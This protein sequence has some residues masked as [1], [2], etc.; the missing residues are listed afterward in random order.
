[1]KKVSMAAAGLVLVVGLAACHNDKC[2]D[3]G[4]SGTCCTD[5]G[6]ST[7]KSSS[8]NAAMDKGGEQPKTPAK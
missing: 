8:D 3:E 7:A 5:S 6:K 4:A 2:C 1:M